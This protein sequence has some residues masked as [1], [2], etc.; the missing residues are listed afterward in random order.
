MICGKG[1]VALGKKYAEALGFEALPIIEV[2]DEI[3]HVSPEELSDIAKQVAKEIPVLIERYRRS[4]VSADVSGS[5]EPDE[6]EVEVDADM[7]TKLSDLFIDRGWSDGLPI[8]PP[9]EERVGAMLKACRLE[10]DEILGVLPPRGGRA[11]AKK[12]AICAVMAG[13]EPVQFPIVVAAVYAISRPAFHLYFVQSTAASH[14]PFIMVNG[15]LGKEAGLSNGHNLT[16]RGWRANISIARAVRLVIITM[17]GIKGVVANHTQGYLGRFVDCIRENEEENPWQPYHVE[18]GYPK[19][20]S[21]VT[22]FQADPPHVVDDHG[23]TSP[24]SLLT[25]YAMT[26]AA[27]G[28]RGIWGATEQIFLIAPMHANYLASQNFSKS[29]IRDFLYEVAR[30][31]LHQFPKDNFASLSKWHQKLFSHVSE[32][33]TVPVVRDKQDFKMI[34]FGGVGPH[35]MYTHGSQGPPRSVTVEVDTVIKSVS[36]IRQS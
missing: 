10:G 6:L 7:S 30:V 25:T 27:A 35:S 9:T 19:D 16:A 5:S 33:V 32:H 24:Q 29:D 34:V 28:N 11:T 14:S 36:K 21:V 4:A 12:V 23:S 3:G 31:P 17:A 22:V 20:A 2:I 26:I 13:C 15:P 8:V 1:F 18:L